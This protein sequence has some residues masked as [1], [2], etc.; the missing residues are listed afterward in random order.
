MRQSVEEYVRCCDKCQTQ[1][2]KQ[3]FRTPLGEVETPSEPFQFVSLDITGPCFVTPRKNR[4]LLT[5]IDHF[6]KYVEAFPIP[7]VSVKTCARVDATQILARHGSGSTVITDQGRSF[8]SAF[9]QEMR[10]ILKVRKVRTSANN[11]M[12]KG[13]VE[14]FNRVLQDSIAH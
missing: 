5:F 6:S 8:T 11:A 7:D 4:Y 10:N 14:R 1:K 12:S 9:F 3:E 13:M 2:G